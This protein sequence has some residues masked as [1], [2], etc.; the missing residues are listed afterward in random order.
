MALSLAAKA[1]GVL[2]KTPGARKREGAA[3]NGLPR[4]G[5]KLAIRK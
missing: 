3:R 5:Y 4:L 1:A 2:R